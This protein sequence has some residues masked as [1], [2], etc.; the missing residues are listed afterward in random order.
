LWV[1]NAQAQGIVTVI[2]AVPRDLAVVIKQ[3]GEAKPAAAAA[4]VVETKA[5]TPATEE[6]APAPEE[7]VEAAPAAEVAETTEATAAEEAPAA[8]ESAE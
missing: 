7:T 3:I 5:E 8:E 6:A 4:P 1:I 2:N